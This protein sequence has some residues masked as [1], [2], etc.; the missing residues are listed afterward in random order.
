MWLVLH[1]R[2]YVEIVEPAFCREDSNNLLL[3]RCLAKK[4]YVEYGRAVVLAWAA[5]CVDRWLLHGMLATMQVFCCCHGGINLLVGEG[6]CG[7]PCNCCCNVVAQG[8]M[9]KVE[10]RARINMDAL[11]AMPYNAGID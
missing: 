2:C 4:R 8:G 11:M 10:T 9:R 7:M 6:C 1:L 5:A 3:C